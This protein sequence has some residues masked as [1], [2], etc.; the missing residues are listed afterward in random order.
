MNSKIV[1]YKKEIIILKD[2]ISRLGTLLEDE[3]YFNLIG[4]GWVKD[5]LYETNLLKKK[6]DLIPYEGMN[7][8]FLINKVKVLNYKWLIAN[9]SDGMHWGE[10]F[11]GY[12]ILPNSKV[13]FELKE[14]LLYP[15]SD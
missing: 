13:T 8:T 1:T 14:H 10:I 3:R 12:K 6:N 15:I 11:L 4:N 5:E 9:F 2:S 7:R